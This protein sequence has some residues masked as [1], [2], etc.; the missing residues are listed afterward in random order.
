L[1]HAYQQIELTEGSKVY[2]TTNTQ[3]SLFHYERLAFGI[4]PA[5]AI[6]QRTMDSL[7]QGFSKVCMYIDDILVSG[8][9]EEEHFS[10]TSK[11]LST[12]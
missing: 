3:K 6:F 12:N 1:S 9:T 11:K 7:F 10:V 5:P 4:S 8:S 2:T